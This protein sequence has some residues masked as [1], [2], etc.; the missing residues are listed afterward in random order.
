MVRL[1]VRHDADLHA[2]IRP[3]VLSAPAAIS[4]I[5]DRLR[6]NNDRGQAPS[7]RAVLMLVKRA[8]NMLTRCLTV[9]LL[10]RSTPWVGKLGHL[11]HA[12]R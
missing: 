8:I 6:V 3:A 10:L 1:R 5:R 2:S 12:D 9:S 4:T 11:R 7:A